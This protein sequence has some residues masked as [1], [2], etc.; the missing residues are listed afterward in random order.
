MRGNTSYLATDH[1]F[2]PSPGPEPATGSAVFTTRQTSAGS[3]EHGATVCVI[4]ASPVS[5]KSVRAGKVACVSLAVARRAGR[6]TIDPIVCFL[7]CAGF[8]GTVDSCCATAVGVIEGGPDDLV[9]GVLF[10][11]P[12]NE[13]ARCGLDCFPTSDIAADLLIA[14]AISCAS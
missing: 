12:A 6:H 14:S 4:L 13:I 1:S 8:S 9:N 2:R 3:S 10:E 5:A 11:V 7:T